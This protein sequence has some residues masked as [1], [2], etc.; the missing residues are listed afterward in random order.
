MPFSIVYKEN[1]IRKWCSHNDKNSKLSEKLKE[2]VNWF[3]WELTVRGMAMS[4]LNV[5]CI[6]CM[7]VPK[8]IS[9]FW[10]M[11]TLLFSLFQNYFLNTFTQW[12]SA[13]LIQM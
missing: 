11:L 5:V 3:N 2:I 4:M 1:K 10:L 8:Q 7:C 13:H 9:Y 6:L 12:M